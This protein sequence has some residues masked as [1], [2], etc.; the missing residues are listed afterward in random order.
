MLLTF[1]ETRAFASR[2]KSRADD[3][4]LRTLQNDLLEAPDRGK[5]IRGCGILRKYRFADP[6]RGKG[7]RGGLR[8]IYLHT[9]SVSRIDFLAVF[10]KDE[11]VD[12]S[13]DEIKI[14]CQLAHAIR[15]EAAA[16]WKGKK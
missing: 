5:A 9:P 8:V 12:L 7:K 10:G 1:V 6:S 14:L 13:R 11:K 16:I 15:E 4:T 2:W 3:E